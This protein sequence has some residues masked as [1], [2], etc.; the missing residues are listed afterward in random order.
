[1]IE[2]SL[3][4]MLQ[5]GVHFGHRTRFWN[6]K[7]S[8]YIFGSREKVHIINLEK[9]KP[10]FE[11]ALT[12]IA[13]VVASKGKVVFVGTKRQA[14]GYVKEQAERCGMPYVNKRWP[15]GMLTN[16]KTIRQSIKR[17]KDLEVQEEMG[18]FD[19]LSKK[20][21]L[22]IQREK[23]KLENSFGGIKE[24][25]GLPDAVFVLDVGHEKIA[26]EEANKLGIPV[27][28]IVDTNN[29][30]EGI[31]YPVPGNDDAQ[32]S[33]LFYSRVV[34]DVIMAV[35]ER[36][37]AEEEKMAKRTPIVE[38]KTAAKAAPAAQKAKPAAK[39]AAAKPVKATKAA[40]DKKP[41]DAAAAEPAKPEAAPA[42]KAAAKKPAAKKAAAKPA[43]KKAD[44]KKP[45]AKKAAAKKPAAKKAAAKPAAKK[46]AKADKADKSE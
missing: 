15:G 28:G 32:K 23:S 4:E 45:A 16:Y 13:H 10:M 3:R 17:L 21:R 9:T 19:M 18:R 30:P 12:Y 39:K 14:Q 5:A 2:I 26:V 37:Q 41:A 36:Q 33:I 43:A 40:A 7:M 11:D 46:A 8:P 42:K 6:P 22:S 27:I 44:A 29:S 1:M 31:D 20:E 25:G 34:A 38:A 24:M 35:K